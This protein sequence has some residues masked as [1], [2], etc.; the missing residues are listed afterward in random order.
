MLITRDMLEA[1]RSKL[2]VNYDQLMSD[3]NAVSG[4]IQDVDHW[5]SVLDEGPG[6]RPLSESSESSQT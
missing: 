4:A 5:I 2:Q 6:D 3:L 1:R